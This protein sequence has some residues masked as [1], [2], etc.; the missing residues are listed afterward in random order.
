MKNPIKITY[1]PWK[2][3][4]VRKKIIFKWIFFMSAAS[5]ELVHT[6]LLSKVV[7]F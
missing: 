4:I 5:L 7:F 2:K 1:L 6:D 3:I